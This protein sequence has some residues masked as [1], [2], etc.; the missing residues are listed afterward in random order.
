MGELRVRMRD[1]DGTTRA[2][3]VEEAGGATSELYSTRNSVAA[4]PCAR[5]GVVWANRR[6]RHV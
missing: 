6:R 3:G 5:T 2:H 1:K 4:R